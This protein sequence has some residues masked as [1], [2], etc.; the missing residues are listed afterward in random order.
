MNVHVI[1]G[2]LSDAT[3]IPESLARIIQ[4]LNESIQGPSI[5]NHTYLNPKQLIQFTWTYGHFT[6]LMGLK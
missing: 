2:G 1:V 6:V 5:R 3:K 4:A